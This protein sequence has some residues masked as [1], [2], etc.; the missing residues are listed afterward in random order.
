MGSPQLAQTAPMSGGYSRE[1]KLGHYAFYFGD[2]TN[3]EKIKDYSEHHAATLHFPDAYSGSNM[4]LRDT[5]TNLITSNVQSWCTMTALP[6]MR[7]QGL[8]VEWDENKFDV[9]LLQRVPYEGVSR[10]QTSIRRKHR[11]RLSPIKE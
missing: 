5:L 7:V 11:E 4:K 1:D 6:W 2:P 9:R 10:L 8:E 3:P